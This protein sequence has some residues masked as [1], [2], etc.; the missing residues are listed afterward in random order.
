VYALIDPS[1]VE[2]DVQRAFF[3][4][5]LVLDADGDAP[6]VSQFGQRVLDGCDI[7]ALRHKIIRAKR[8]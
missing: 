1:F 7:T 5:L 8:V 3:M 6:V 2:A 4:G